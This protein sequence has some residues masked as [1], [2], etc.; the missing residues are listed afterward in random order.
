M[1]GGTRLQIFLNFELAVL[2]LKGE[3]RVE[4]NGHLCNIARLSLF[5]RFLV[6]ELA[7]KLPHVLVIGIAR[8]WE[9]I[10]LLLGCI[11]SL[12]S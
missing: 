2:D 5:L 4:D 12:C 7:Q 6:A 3:L 10:S 9:P 8:H 1:Q 11:C